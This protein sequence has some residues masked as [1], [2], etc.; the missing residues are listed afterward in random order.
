ML[1]IKQATVTKNDGAMKVADLFGITFPITYFQ[2]V[3]I[4][5]V[6]TPSGWKVGNSDINYTTQK[7]LTFNQLIQNFP[8]H[9][10]VSE[11]LYIL[12]DG[13]NSTDGSVLVAAYF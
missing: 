6:G 13:P 1:T 3:E 8:A 12:V 10:D 7:G 5:Q 11:N 4:D 2:L 9:A